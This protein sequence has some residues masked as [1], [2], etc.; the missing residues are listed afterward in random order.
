M[1]PK[2]KSIELFD[3]YM[4]FKMNPYNDLEMTLKK[5]IAKKN[6]LIAVNEIL[7]LRVIKKQI[8]GYEILNTGNIEYWQE[9]KQEI[10]L[11]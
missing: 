7:K 11:I 3:K 6:A 4:G 10:E 5:G 9:V 2:E 1:T 8:I